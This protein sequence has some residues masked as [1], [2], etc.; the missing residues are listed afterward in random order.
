[1]G[2]IASTIRSGF[3]RAISIGFD[4][5]LASSRRGIGPRAER[6]HDVHSASCSAS[7]VLSQRSQIDIIQNRSQR[8]DMRRP[9][10][11]MDLHGVDGEDLTPA[12]IHRQTQLRGFLCNGSRAIAGGATRRV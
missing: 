2:R 5:V 8:R 10:A 1:M 6:Q 11:H 12:E 4:D 3:V 7:I 9:S